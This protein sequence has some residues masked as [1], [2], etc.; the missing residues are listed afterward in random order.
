MEPTQRAVSVVL[1]QVMIN[2]LLSAY[3]V[4]L[5]HILFNMRQIWLLRLASVFA[6]TYCTSFL[7][8][9]FTHLRTL[10]RRILVLP[11]CRDLPSFIIGYIHVLFV[12]YGRTANS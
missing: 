4:N 12:G 8:F 1:L 5:R 9:T 10:S 11:M 3:Y 6:N 2:P 7:P